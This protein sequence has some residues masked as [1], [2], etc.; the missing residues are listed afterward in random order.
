MGKCWTQGIRAARLEQLLQSQSSFSMDD[1]KRFQLD[2]FSLKGKDIVQHILAVLNP[3][4]EG[5]EGDAHITIDADL[6]L[7]LNLLAKWDYNQSIDSVGGSVYE[8]MKYTTNKNILSPVL[9]DALTNLV[10][11]AYFHNN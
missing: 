1:F 7:G 9:G 5:S 11:P 6:A 4:A 2:T 10:S 3:K 8:V